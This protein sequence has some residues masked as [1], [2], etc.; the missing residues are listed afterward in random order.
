MAFLDKARV[1]LLRHSQA[2]IRRG[3]LFG[4]EIDMK[5]A[6]VG[7]FYHLASEPLIIFLIGTASRAST[8]AAIA[9]EAVVVEN[10]VGI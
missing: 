2:D 4:I 6:P 5:K 7:A 9:S 3:V 10:N 1:F 8:N